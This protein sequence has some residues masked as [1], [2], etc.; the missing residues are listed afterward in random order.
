MQSRKKEKLFPEEGGSEFYLILNRNA[1]SE[2]LTLRA[3]SRQIRD[4][5]Q[6][7]PQGRR[8]KKRVHRLS[9]ARRGEM[10]KSRA[11]YEE[12]CAFRSPLRRAELLV[13]CQNGARNREKTSTR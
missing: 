5:N 13:F 12:R 3:R 1:I 10:A 8:E 2:T 4:A 6:P 9:G 11:N 7:F